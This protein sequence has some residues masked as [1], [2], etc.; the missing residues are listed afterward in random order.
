VREVAEM[1]DADLF[2]ELAAIAGVFVG[3]GALIS[4]RAGGTSDAHEVAY[5]RPV[6]TL[7]ICVVIAALAPVMVSRYGV[8]GHEL[9]LV[10]GLVA[11]VIFLGLWIVNYRTP[12]MR[13]EAATRAR[14]EIVR[15]TAANMLLFVPVVIALV[16]VVLG[17]LPDHE[18]ALYFTAVGLILFLDALNLVLLVF[19]QRHPQ[20]TSDSVELP[21][22]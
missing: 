2:M 6:V 9:W 7:A 17:L 10:C 16:L 22:A 15:G 21:S 18:P 8:T 4:V 11:L 14:A 5:I 12:E 13:E 3:F 1:Q 19:S 20:A